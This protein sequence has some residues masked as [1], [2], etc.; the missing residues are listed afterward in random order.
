M[1]FLHPIYTDD[2]LR[3]LSTEKRR[4]L[5]ALI[6]ALLQTDDDV[7]NFIRGKLQAKFD[8]LKKKKT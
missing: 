7:K 5:S 3:Q 2:D 4:E 8:E 6:A 1:S